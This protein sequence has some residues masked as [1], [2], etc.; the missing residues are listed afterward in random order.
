VY[1]IFRVLEMFRVGYVMLYI[2]DS[3]WS[4]VGC[5]MPSSGVLEGVF[6]GV[7]NVID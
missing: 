2:R 7:A 6:G 1:A 5:V 4:S 3:E